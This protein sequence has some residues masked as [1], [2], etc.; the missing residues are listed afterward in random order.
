MTAQALIG[1]VAVVTGA[2]LGIGRVTAQLFAGAVV[3]VDGGVSI[4]RT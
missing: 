3:I 2:S 4:N 1:K